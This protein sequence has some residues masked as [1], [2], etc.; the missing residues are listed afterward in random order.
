M[1]ILKNVVFLVYL[2]SAIP[3]CLKTLLGTQKTFSGYVSAYVVFIHLFIHS[4]IYQTFTYCLLHACPK[5]CARC[6][7]LMS[8]W[9]HAIMLVHPTFH[10][11]YAPE[12]WCANWVIFKWTNRAWCLRGTLRKILLLCRESFC[13]ENHHILMCLLCKPAFPYASFS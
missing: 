13:D 7:E 4:F 11:E 8:D 3:S 5:H 9:V 2:T 1:K 10:N 6:W 12:N